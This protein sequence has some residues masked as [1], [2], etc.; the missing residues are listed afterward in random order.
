MDNKEKNITSINNVNSQNNVGSFPKDNTSSSSINDRINQTKARN[1][2]N[3]IHENND[4]KPSPLNSIGDT[5]LNEASKK[6]GIVGDTAKTINTVKKTKKTIQAIKALLAFITGPLGIGSFVFMGVF[7]LILLIVII[8]YT[9][10]SSLSMKYNLT[11]KDSYEVFSEKYKEAMSRGEIDEL[12]GE[13]SS[14][15]DCGTRTLFTKLKNAFGIYD[16]ENPAEL[17]LYVK[18]T[19]E[20]K[21]KLNGLDTLSPGYF[22]SSL[23]YAYDTQ[24]INKDGKLFIQVKDNDKV[25]INSEDYVEPNDIDI[26]S[27][28]FLTKVYTKQDLDTLID[29]YILKYDLESYS[30]LPYELVIKHDEFG[31]EYEECES[32][33]PGDAIYQASETKFNLFL[34]YGSEVSE[35]YQKDLNI[36]KT[37][38]L[39]SSACYGEIG[40]EKPDLTKY[41]AKIDLLDTTEEIPSIEGYT[42][43][44]GFVYT[45]YPRYLKE[46]TLDNKKPEFNY[47]IARDIESILNERVSSRQDYINYLLGYPNNVKTNILSYSGSCTYSVNNTN[48]DNLYVRLLHGGNDALPN[49]EGGT[50]IEGQELIEFEDYILGVVYAESGAVSD[51]A[52]KVQ[53]IT[54]RNYAL[55]NGKLV[56]EDDKNIIEI[57]NSTEAQT[58]CDPDLGCTRYYVEKHKGTINVYTK[59]T[60]PKSE[61]SPSALEISTP[62][63]EKDSRVRKAVKSVS[64]VLLKDLSGNL[65]SLGYGRDEQLKWDDLAKSGSDYTEIIRLTYGSDFTVSSPSCSFASGDWDAWRQFSSEWGSIML[66]NKTMS[67]VGCF[68][69]AHAKAIAKSGA[70]VKVSNFNPGTFINIIKQNSCLSGNN[71]IS[72]C[73][74]N[75]VLV[76]KYERKSESLTGSLQNKANIISSYLNDGYEV[77]LR[78]KSPDPRQHWVLVTGVNGSTIYMSDTAS[79]VNT[80]VPFYNASEVVYLIAYKFDK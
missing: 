56:T 77:L 68:I 6:E 39:T 65:L 25:D 54:A 20:E 37:Y 9:I 16:V 35:M 42:Y 31:N 17:C 30:L 19:L 11:G 46:Y 51:E 38:E 15:D 57:R 78:V 23:Y 45:T 43:E 8:F 1:L 59:G 47:K 60:E 12:Y 71:L 33:N 61:L 55:K 18:K 58:Y 2:Q 29:E 7:I 48:L 32:F 40:V 34:R 66:S 53:A 76:N 64:G 75:S 62:P 13:V 52:L 24:N 80:V 63:L 50:A 4:F 22:L 72:A 67:K 36:I 26:I 44:S 41:D 49:I 79:N 10:F 27:T 28:L 70:Q 3:N 14:S 74:L 73:A 21:E 69:T 5:V